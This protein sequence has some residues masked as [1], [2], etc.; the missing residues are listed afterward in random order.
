MIKNHDELDKNC[1][2]TYALNPKYNGL[3]IDISIMFVENIKIYRN[4]DIFWKNN[5]EVYIFSV[6][7]MQQNFGS[8]IIFDT[9]YFF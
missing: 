4:D 3:Q 1:H 9:Y 5:K 7:L 2:C 8:V 6:S